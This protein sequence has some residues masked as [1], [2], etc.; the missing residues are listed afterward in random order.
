M[1]PGLRVRLQRGG[2]RWHP[3]EKRLDAGTLFL[4]GGLRQEARRV[5]VGHASLVSPPCVAKYPFLNW[6]FSAWL[7]HGRGQ[8]V[9]ESYSRDRRAGVLGSFLG[10]EC[11]LQWS[12][13]SAEQLSAPR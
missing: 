1:V 4:K 7:F 11:S 8:E 13:A 6:C 2:N 10:T 3:G 12:A 5:S 9:R